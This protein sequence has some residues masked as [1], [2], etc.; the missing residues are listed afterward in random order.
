MQQI[1]KIN[2]KLELRPFKSEDAAELFALTEK[3]REY[4]RQWLPWLDR[5]RTEKDSAEFIVFT[6]SEANKGVGFTFGLFK[7][8]VLVGVASFQN[9][10]KTNRAANIGYWISRDQAGQGFARA[11]TKA[12][13]QHAFQ[14]MNLN[15]IEIRCA[16]EN[17]ASQKVAEACGLSY[18]GYARSCEWLYDHF[19]DHKTYSI[20]SSDSRS[21]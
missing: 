12:M 8:A 9:I 4:L 15:R 5:T 19:V 13:I 17:V 20:L 21:E 11:M 2:D 16:A 3:N 7:N 6:A 1:L 14:S 18:E 10:N